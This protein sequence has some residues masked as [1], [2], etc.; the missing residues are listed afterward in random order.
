MNNASR[1][2]LAILSF[3]NFVIGTGTLIIAGL[4]NEMA[5]DLQTS[6]V[7]VGQLL[8]GYALAVCFG[9]PILAGLTSRIDR[10]MLLVGALTIFA[11]G[12]LLAAAAPNY[13]ILMVLRIATGFG[14]AIFTPQAAATAGL[15][16]P[17]E[18]RGRAIA[19]VFLG[20]SIATVFGIPIGAYLGSAFGWR[21]A[22][23][24]VGGLSVICALLLYAQLPKQLKVQP[25]DAA[26]WK[27]V[28]TNA[29]LLLVVAV[30]IVQASAQFV[31]FTYIAPALKD[32]V[33]A[34]P[35]TLSLTLMWFGICGV[36][37]NIIGGSLID[38]IGTP[39]VVAISIGLMLAGFLLWPFGHGSLPLIATACALWGLG[40]FAIN[41]AQQARL[42]GLA[43]QLAPVSMALNSSAIYLGQAF[44]AMAGGLIIAH[45]GVGA[46]SWVGA[47]IFVLALGVS[48]A[49]Q[50]MT[51]RSFA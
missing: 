4:L 47:I 51:Q 48:F 25:I 10:R 37:G 29:P 7:A 36:V 28:W 41:S 3:G 39:H 14:A 50:R 1:T 31:L 12:H 21:L 30:T 8:T 16:V 17:A 40:C 22:L 33:A 5:A 24:V 35:S 19:T 32:S 34:G 6:I 18:Q 20:F 42:V 9:A 44:G 49:A 13:A 2:P 26:A 38:R 45:Q 11:A 23:A 43:T 46:L 27:S 15:L